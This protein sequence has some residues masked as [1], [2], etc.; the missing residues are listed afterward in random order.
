M[1]SAWKTAF[2]PREFIRNLNVCLVVLLPCEFPQKLPFPDGQVKNKIHK[3]DGKLHQPWA[4]KN[5]FL[6]FARCDCMFMLS[7]PAA[8]EYII[9]LHQQKKKQEE[10]L[11]AL[12]KEVMA[13]KI[14]KT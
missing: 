4:I 11:E 12:R 10:E 8:I 3:P 7:F 9:F 1:S 2:D 13:L 5:D 14:M 6:I